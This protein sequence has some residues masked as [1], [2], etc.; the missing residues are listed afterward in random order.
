MSQVSSIALF[1]FFKLHSNVIGCRYFISCS[2]Y[3]ASYSRKCW[4][5]TVKQMLS[6][7]SC[8]LR[9]TSMHCLRTWF[10]N[11]QAS[12][13]GRQTCMVFSCG[14]AT[15]F[16]DKTRRFY[17]LFGARADS[18]DKSDQNR[19]WSPLL[20][21]VFLRVWILSFAYVWSLFSFC[22]CFS[23]SGCQTTSSDRSII[24][25]YALYEP[26]CS[27]CW[28]RLLVTKQACLANLNIMSGLS[29]QKHNISAT[30]DSLLGYSL[31]SLHSLLP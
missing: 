5:E 11:P 23:L 4:P 28:R 1:F 19:V 25:F 3:R 9:W 29:C 27:F 17:R 6:R 12:P 22:H 16:Q 26:Q 13:C 20:L 14:P 30:F 31:S 2:A 10:V 7:V 21:P 24:A 15:L 8:R 18:S